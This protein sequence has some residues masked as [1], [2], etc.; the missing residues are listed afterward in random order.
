VIGRTALLLAALFALTPS[1]SFA[2][3]TARILDVQVRRQGPR[4]SI[5]LQMTF[6]E[7]PRAVFA[8]LQDYH[9]MPRY[10]HDLRAVRVEPTSVPGT[11]ML[12]TAVHACVLVFCRTLHQ[13][14]L[15]T[16]AADTHGGTLRALLLPGGSFRSGHA[17]WIVRPCTPR[18]A[19]TC[20]DLHIEL[21]PAFWV[22][23]LIGPWALL[24]TMIEEARRS[25]M[26]LMHVAAHLSASMAHRAAAR[27]AVPD[28]SDRH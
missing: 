19:L 6:R 13:T 14:Q 15:M 22:P 25:G 24:R 18:H 10:N 3:A 7:S 23:P 9:A 16:G 17:R 28:S 20:L 5:K 26:G 21:E 2:S 12:F 27:P 1:P 11:V 4:F 8:A